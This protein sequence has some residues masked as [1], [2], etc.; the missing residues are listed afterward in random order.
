VYWAQVAAGSA[1]A[2][3]YSLEFLIDAEVACTVSVCLFAK[4]V[5]GEH[6]QLQYVSRDTRISFP[7]VR[8]EPGFRQ[9]CVVARG[10]CGVVVP[11]ISLQ[12]LPFFCFARSYRFPNFAMPPLHKYADAMLFHDPAATTFP[13]V[14][15][16]EVLLSFQPLVLHL[17][18]DPPHQAA[19]PSPASDSGVLVDPTHAHATLLTFDATNHETGP[20]RTFS[21]RVLA[22]KAVIDGVVFL[23]K[24]MYGVEDKHAAADLN[25]ALSASSNAGLGNQADDDDEATECVVRHFYFIFVVQRYALIN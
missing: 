18:A 3:A 25:P 10:V 11:P 9:L 6:G 20:Q 5:V 16:V 23:L 12:R 21:V 15:L 19:P 1:G 14:V 24:D 4:E 13:L 8:F 7:P 17:M 22:Q 2:G